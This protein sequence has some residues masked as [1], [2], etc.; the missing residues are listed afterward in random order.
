[1]VTTHQKVVGSLAHSPR[2]KNKTNGS[3]WP[4]KLS[5][6]DNCSDES[7]RPDKLFHR[8]CVRRRHRIRGDLSTCATLRRNALPHE[9][10]AQTCDYLLRPPQSFANSETCRSPYKVR[11]PRH[12]FRDRKLRSR[13]TRS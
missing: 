13:D 12:V 2:H 9:L 5:V 4:R 1:M 3:L 6:C 7:A 8:R 10:A 11:S